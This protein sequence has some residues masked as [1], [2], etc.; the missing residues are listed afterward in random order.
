MQPDTATTRP[1]GRTA[2]V[3]TA[4]RDATIAELTEHGYA[5]LTVENVAERSGVHKTTIYRRWGGVDG[6]IVNALDLA[7]QDDWAPPDT[8]TLAGDLTGFVHEVLEL[9]TDPVEG[10]APAVFIAATFHSERAAEAMTALYVDRHARASVAVT[11]AIERGELPAGTEAGAVVRAAVAP[12]YY[13]LFITREPIDKHTADQAVAA[14]LAA[15]HA[16]V[17]QSPRSDLPSR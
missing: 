4:V 3:A 2:R 17:F 13:R 12:L 16:G 10:V 9:F 14:A 1:G 15:A 5:G 6:L 8:G 7:S 11:R